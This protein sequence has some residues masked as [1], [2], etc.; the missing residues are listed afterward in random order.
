M[1]AQAVFSWGEFAWQ[2]P[3][4]SDAN[5]SASDAPPCAL[6]GARGGGYLP[7]EEVR[8]LLVGR[9][10]LFVGN[11]VLRQ[12]MWALVDEF[13]AHAHRRTKQ[14]AEH[15]GG[16]GNKWLH[17]IETAAEQAGG[18]A[19]VFDN[20]D[21]NHVAQFTARGRDGA[22]TPPRGAQRSEPWRMPSTLY[23][24][25]LCNV[26]SGVSKRL[27]E[28][29]PD[30]RVTSEA[31]ARACERHQCRLSQ[32][33]YCPRGARAA[34]FLDAEHCGTAEVCFLYAFSGDGMLPTLPWELLELPT[35]RES[36]NLGV[37]ADVLVLQA[38][39]P[40]AAVAMLEGV[41]LLR[42]DAAR[43]RRR[44]PRADARVLYFEPTHCRGCGKRSA[45]QRAAVMRA[46]EAAGV[47]VV[48]LSD[49]SAAGIDGGFLHHESENGFHYLDSGREFAAQMIAQTLAWME[50]ADSEVGAEAANTAVR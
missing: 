23:A 11:S 15:A 26:S 35:G 8:R 39:D 25:R 28:R 2:R 32:G 19:V 6:A 1:F 18:H 13:D 9:R 24:D 3:A 14:W 20:P 17:D 12:T 36:R 40:A 45:A 44:W 49:A 48:P 27:R 46:A 22:G 7:S 31:E 47:A 33:L 41:R 10:L 30:A 4:G 29:N 43:G 50:A 38:R 5:A 34:A 37:G 16:Q 42:D 21:Y